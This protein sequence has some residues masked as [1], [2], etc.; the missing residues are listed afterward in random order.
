VKRLVVCLFA[1]AAFGASPR[2]IVEVPA[3]LTADWMRQQA[4]IDH[5]KLRQIQAVAQMNDYCE[6]NAGKLQK[7]RDADDDVIFVCV[8]TG[9]P[10]K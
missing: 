5:A 3:N 7:T 4:N 6:M 8:P 2:P 1:I 10:A 9:E